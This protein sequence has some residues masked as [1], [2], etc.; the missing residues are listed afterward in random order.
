MSTPQIY[1][2]QDMCVYC[3][4]EKHVAYYV[5][6]P[7]EVFGRPFVSVSPLSQIKYSFNN[8]FEDRYFN[9]SSGFKLLSCFCPQCGVSYDIHSF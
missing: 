1:L 8:T 2:K 3:Q 7:Q 9:L 4:V 6:Q 5:P